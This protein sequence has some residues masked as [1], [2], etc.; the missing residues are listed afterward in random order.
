MPVGP[1]ESRLTATTKS[2]DPDA[3]MDQAANDYILAVRVRHAGSIIMTHA[4]P[5][6]RSSSTSECSRNLRGMRRPHLQ[7]GRCRW[8][9]QTQAQVPPPKVGIIGDSP[10]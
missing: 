1:S 7:D 2:I 10:N 8:C 9:S 5:R 4:V 6:E 3:F